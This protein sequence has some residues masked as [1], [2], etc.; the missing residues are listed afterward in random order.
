MSALPEPN[1]LIVEVIGAALSAILERTGHAVAAEVVH[2][3]ADR[4]GPAFVQGQINQ[5][6]LARAAADAA[7]DVKFGPEKKET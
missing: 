2:V 6:V 4:L 7:E 5:Y 1:A 3:V